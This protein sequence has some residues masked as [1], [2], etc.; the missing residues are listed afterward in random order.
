MHSLLKSRR[1]WVVLAVVSLML[2]VGWYTSASPRGMLMARID[3]ARGHY[4]VKTYG[5]PPPTPDEAEMYTEYARLLR[6]RYGVE[7]NDVAQCVV[8]EELARYANGYNAV[9]RRLLI[10]KYGR[11]IFKECAA[12]A[13][14]R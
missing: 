9:S 5:G 8:A 6:E 1:V 11:D 7:L 4:E 12:S 2:V 13:Q 14:R 10:E 3:H